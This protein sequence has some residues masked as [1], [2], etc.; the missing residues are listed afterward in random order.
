MYILPKQG[1]GEEA[2][3]KTHLPHYRLTITGSLSFFH[4]RGQCRH[5]SQ[6]HSLNMLLFVP[7]LIYWTFRSHL[8]GWNGFC[9]TTTPTQEP[10]S[11]PKATN[12]PALPNRA[13][14][15]KKKGSPGASDWPQA[16]QSRT[17]QSQWQSSGPSHSVPRQ[18]CSFAWRQSLQAGWMSEA[19]SSTKQT[20]V[21]NGFSQASQPDQQ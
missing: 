20:S 16:A 1:P 15:K 5:D 10:R 12:P 8:E 17:G 4:K 6:T 14:K 21:P 18:C 19:V 7:G 11:L 13:E 9:A 2:W 3:N